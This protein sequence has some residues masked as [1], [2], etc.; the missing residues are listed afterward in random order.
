M[1]IRWRDRVHLGS[2]NDPECFILISFFC[3][4]CH[5]MCSRI[6]ILILKSM[7]IIKMRI[8]TADCFC[9][10]IHH[11]DK[12]LY[13]STDMLGNCICTFIRRLKHDTIETLL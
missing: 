2:D 12:I 3:D 7:R 6:M 11:I 5:V 8:R 4:Q 9:P 1:L 13:C 10:C